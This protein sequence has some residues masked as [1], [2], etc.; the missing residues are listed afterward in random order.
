LH[1][2]GR[3]KGKKEEKDIKSRIK[4]KVEK[5]LIKMAYFKE[6]I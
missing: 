4:N 6:K 3:K 2:A 1:P 5:A